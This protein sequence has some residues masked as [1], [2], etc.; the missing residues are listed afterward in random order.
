MRIL[1]L[2]ARFIFDAQWI[3]TPQKA[4][5]LSLSA[6]NQKDCECTR[7]YLLKTVIIHASGI[8]LFRDLFFLIVSIESLSKLTRHIIG[9]VPRTAAKYCRVL[10]NLSN[11][12][13]D[14]SLRAFVIFRKL[15]LFS[16]NFPLALTNVFFTV[17]CEQIVTLYVHYRKE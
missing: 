10:L 13:S 16:G 12:S 7:L 3:F 6:D 2:N 1:K 9:N 8:L 4:L 14:D 17:C 11:F 5:I 15:M